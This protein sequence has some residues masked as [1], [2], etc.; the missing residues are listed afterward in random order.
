M[1]TAS[2]KAD[3]AVL[4]KLYPTRSHSG[5]TQ[6]GFNAALREDD[7]VEARIFDTVKDSDYVGDQDAIEVLCSEVPEVIMALSRWAFPGSGGKTSWW[8]SVP[9][10][11]LASRL[12]PGL[13]RR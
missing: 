11:G 13:F 6:G 12:P 1:L 2:E 3:I 8:P 9:W 7:S 10:A 4:S 5:A